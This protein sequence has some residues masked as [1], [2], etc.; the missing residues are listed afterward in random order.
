M[1]SGPRWPGLGSATTIP[2]GPEWRQLWLTCSGTSL[3][4]PPAGSRCYCFQATVPRDSHGACLHT[5]VRDVFHVK[6]PR[7][8]LSN[9][10]RNL[11]A[12]QLIHEDVTPSELKGPG[13]RD[14]KFTGIA[15]SNVGSEMRLG[16]DRRE[17]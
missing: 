12:R 5:A 11:S 14:G 3:Q 15:L 17:R 13:G 16:L 8:S 4:P 10:S 7:A 2:Q 9:W 1:A 6:N